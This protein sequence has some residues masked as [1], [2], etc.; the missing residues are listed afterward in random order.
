MAVRV[1]NEKWEG[2]LTPSEAIQ[3]ATRASRSGDGLLRR[4]A[5]EL[6]LSCLPHSQ[7][8]S[9]GDITQT[10]TLCREQDEEMLE[11]ACSAVENAGRNGGV[12]PELLFRIAREWHYL[13]EEK[14]KREGGNDNQNIRA[15]NQRP[16]GS[17]VPA[18]RSDQQVPVFMTPEQFVQEQMHLQAQEML[19]R[20]LHRNSTQDQ[21]TWIYPQY[22]G[23]LHHCPLPQQAMHSR[24]IQN[25][26]AYGLPISNFPDEIESFRD[27]TI[28][29]KLVSRRYASIGG[30]ISSYAERSYS[31]QVCIGTTIFRGYSVDVCLISFTGATI[32]EEFLQGCI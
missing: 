21:F 5:A 22:V 18:F 16:S 15:R 20:Q 31:C 2:I 12:Q 6:A 24:R 19:G 1:L 3:T 26:D 7:S 27:T 32:F 23:P 30:I 4:T 17:P 14:R 29:A 9:P 13:H 10:I 28:S 25:I 11:R 8:L